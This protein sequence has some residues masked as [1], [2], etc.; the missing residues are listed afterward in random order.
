MVKLGERILNLFSNLLLIRSHCLVS[1]DR[2][3]FT[4]ILMQLT[5]LNQFNVP[6]WIKIQTNI[7]A[8]TYYF[9]PFPNLQ[10]AKLSQH[11]YIEDL[12]K[13]KA[14]G[15]TVEL[16]KCQPKILTICEEETQLSQST[17]AAP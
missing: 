6:W 17:Q 7:P 10:E 14:H 13:E 1:A 2:L 15:I 4:K 16:K 8:C 5:H 9:G 3:S 12:V 11:G